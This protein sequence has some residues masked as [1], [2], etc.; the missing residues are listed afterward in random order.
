V[1]FRSIADLAATI[2]MQIHRVPA[3][4]DLVVGV[5]R[6]GMLAASIIALGLNRRLIDLN[7]WLSDATIANGRT[8]RVAGN[9]PNTPGEAKSLLLVDDSV[10]TGQSIEAAKQSILQT[11]FEGQLTTLAVYAAPSAR[12]KVS[13]HFETV[14]MPRA[15][16]W[17]VMHRVE[18][19]DCCLDLDGVLCVDPTEDENDDGLR[20]CRFLRSAS[21]R[22]IPTYR[23]GHIVT[24]RLERFRTETEEWLQNH[25]VSYGHLHMLDV[26][27]AVT[28][29]RLHLHAS[30]KASV[31][32]RQRETYLFI[33]SEP[34]QSEEIAAAS[35][36]PVLCFST[37]QLHRPGFSVATVEAAGASLATRISRSLERVRRRLATR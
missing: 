1:N 25:N 33:E 32:R 2:R 30:F 15:F 20:Y 35:G 22:V 16:E 14:S 9:A 3:N 29:R 18:L 24:S 11:G 31:Y 10:L 13:V 26:P 34:G 37:Q 23:V 5:P 7:H 17:N 28:R 6:S 19:A 12:D 8:R 36:K 21:P 4:V 27:D